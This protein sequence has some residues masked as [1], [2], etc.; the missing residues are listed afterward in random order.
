MHTPPTTPTT[1]RTSHNSRNSRNSRNSPRTPRTPTTAKGNIS[2][3]VASATFTETTG[4]LPSLAAN[5]EKCSWWPSFAIKI[6][7]LINLLETENY[8]L[9]FNYVITG[10][11][12]VALLA[13]FTNK[14]ALL[15][16]EAPNDGDIII[17]PIET[18]KRS[19]STIGLFNIG[20]YVIG[21]N[22]KEE[23]S[24]TFKKPEELINTIT[25]K[26][27]DVNIENNIGYITL[28]N[29]IKILSPKILL[30]RYTDNFRNQNIHKHRFLSSRNSSK[31]TVSKFKSGNTNKNT[32]HNRMRSPIKIKFSFNN[33][34]TSG[35]NSGNHRVNNSGNNRVNNSGTKTRLIF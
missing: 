16:L 20:S 25:F 7:N 2:G 11:S 33:S 32:R 4:V 23:N 3:A 29:N 8:K 13:Y 17:I 35:N 21:E 6:T 28:D 34:K 9:L 30:K 24:A 14:D 22:Q 1:P 18:S 5:P 27:I 12:A 15:M 26:S 10:S 19:F 31:N